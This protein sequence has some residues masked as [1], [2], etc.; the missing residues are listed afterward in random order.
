MDWVT[1]LIYIVMVVLGW[2]NIYAAVYDENVSQNIFSMSL[3]SGRQLLFI[4]A[5]FVI[6]LGI[7]IVDMRFYET[8]AYVVYGVVIFTMLLVPIIGKEV[9]GQGSQR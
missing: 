4:G 5:S 6:I 2:L 3:N 7:L 9:G 1:V 8:A